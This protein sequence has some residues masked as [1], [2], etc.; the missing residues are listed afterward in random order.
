[1]VI[2]QYWTEQV[3]YINQSINKNNETIVYSSDAPNINIM[4]ESDYRN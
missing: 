3:Y 1:M 4:Y 2:T